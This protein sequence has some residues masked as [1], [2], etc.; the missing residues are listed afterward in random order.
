MKT[1]LVLMATGLTTVVVAQVQPVT[2]TP[3]ITEEVLANPGMGWETF[4]QTSKQ[5]KSL[6]PWIPSTV[7]YARWGWGELEPQPGKINHTFLDKIL[8]ETRE[9]GQ[10]LA[11]RV[12]CCSTSKGLPYHPKWL[13]DVGGNERLQILQV[14]G[15]GEPHEGRGR[16]LGRF[17]EDTAVDVDRRQGM[18]GLRRP[19]RCRMAG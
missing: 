12:M 1:A 4:H 6:P 7:H 13:K 16:I 8:S 14:A 11:F 15:A 19:P 2:I 3:E 10:K 17:Q 5:D 9:A 18:L